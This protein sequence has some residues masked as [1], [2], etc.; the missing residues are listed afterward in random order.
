MVTYGSCDGVQ[1]LRLCT[2]IF[3]PFQSF[4]GKIKSTQGFVS[5]SGIHKTEIFL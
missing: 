3:F 4:G 2:T 1:K 5:V